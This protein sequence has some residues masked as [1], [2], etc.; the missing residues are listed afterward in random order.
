[1]RGIRACRR[2]T[3]GFCS[4]LLWRSGASKRYW[5]RKPKTFRD[6]QIDHFVPRNPRGGPDLNI[7]V[8][9]PAN[10]APICDPATRRRATASSRARALVILEDVQGMPLAAVFDDIRKYFGDD[11]DDGVKR[12]SRLDPALGLLQLGHSEQHLQ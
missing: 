4:W 6:L 8:D 2:I 12:G 9:G 11:I 1:M 3:T 5:C 10:L 7:D